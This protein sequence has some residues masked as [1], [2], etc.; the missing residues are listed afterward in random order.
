MDIREG[1][2]SQR[3]Q[4]APSGASRTSQRPRLMR[5]LLVSLSFPSDPSM[6]HGVFRRLDLLVDGLR[7]LG[8]LDVLF[9]VDE[10]VDLSAG[11]VDRFRRELGARWRSDLELTLVRRQPGGTGREAG[12]WRAYGA[13]AF[14]AFRHPSFGQASGSSQ[15]VA[16][17]A[18][19]E[20]R[21]DV[22]F[23]HRLAAM[24]PVLGTRRPL[25]PVVFD[26]DD[27]EHRS[28]ARAIREPP[29]WPAKYLSYLQLP[30]LWW[31]ER[32]AMV[33]ADRTFVC[34]ASDREYLRR[35]MHVDGVEVIP[36]AVE[37]VEPAPLPDAPTALFLGSLVYP[38]NRNAAVYLMREIWPRVRREIPDAR[39]T[40]AGRNPEAVPGSNSPPPGIEF[41]GFVEDLNPLYAGI[42]VVCAPIFAGGGTRIKIVEAAAHGRPVVATSL[43]AEG[44]ELRDGREILLR[45]EPERFA[46]AVID[47][48]RDDERARQIGAAGRSAVAETYDRDRIVERIREIVASCANA[49]GSVVERVAPELDPRRHEGAGK[50]PQEKQD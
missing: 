26:L 5:V 16:L 50:A 27:I 43:G 4:P 44:L 11:A 45:D 7:G 3:S 36:N 37:R 35:T 41:S 19:L 33:R 38:P 18:A 6:V 10:D 9:F 20:R 39:L 24:A 2:P 22:L 47:L 1:E 34:S 13:P 25:P 28:L 12:R 17:E 48:M 40:I 8:T 42:R 32:R 23:A 31:A 49:P 29:V 46:A 21:P 15:Q 30:A 14:D